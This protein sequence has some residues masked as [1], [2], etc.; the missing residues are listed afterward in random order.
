MKNYLFYAN[1]DFTATTLIDARHKARNRKW[2]ESDG[3]LERVRFQATS[4][5]EAVRVANQLR[6]ML[7]DAVLSGRVLQRQL[8]PPPSRRL[9]FAIDGHFI[10]EQMGC[11][12][13][14]S[15]EE[16]EKQVHQEEPLATL[17]R[18]PA[19]HCRICKGG[20]K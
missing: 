12:W 20:K 7:E 9:H 11:T 5:K 10:K 16:A 15:K 14:A 19:K 8:T 1:E 17:R 4:W 3:S 13:A 6:R 2:M 18:T